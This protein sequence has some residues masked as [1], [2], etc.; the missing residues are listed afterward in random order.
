MLDTNAL[1]K[2]LQRKIAHSVRRD[3][4]HRILS[5]DE[6]KHLLKLNARCLRLTK[7]ALKNAYHITEDFQA[8]L[9]AGDK[10]YE[11]F[12]VE[13]YVYVNID[14]EKQALA[15]LDGVDLESHVATTS[16]NTDTGNPLKKEEYKR[17]WY[18]NWD[19]ACFTY[20]LYDEKNGKGH[21]LCTVF[22][23]LFDWS[24]LFTVRQLMEILPS[25]IDMRIEINI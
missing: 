17:L 21:S 9:K 4:H 20:S 5:G 12:N 14:Y 1:G 2:N 13:A 11:G 22:C 15:H 6:L 7:K 16:Q 19:P 24:E 8:K 23:E 25:D 3:W 18:G 10:A